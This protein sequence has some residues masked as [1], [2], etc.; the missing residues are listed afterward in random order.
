MNSNQ[1]IA[2]LRQHA[3]ELKAAGVVHLRVFGSVVRGETS[4]ESDIDLLADFDKSKRLTRDGRKT[5]KPSD[6]F[7]GR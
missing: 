7:V 3:P 4:A 2:K 6:G 1:V 5:A